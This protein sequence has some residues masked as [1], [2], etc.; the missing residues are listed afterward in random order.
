MRLALLATG[1]LA[2][3][4]LA[5]AARGV[6]WVT[7]TGSWESVFGSHETFDVETLEAQYGPWYLEVVWGR[8]TT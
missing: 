7:G 2:G 4:A 6:V 3:T 8:W 5:V 1:I